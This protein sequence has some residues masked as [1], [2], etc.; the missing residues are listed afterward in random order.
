MPASRSA[1]TYT[2]R[3]APE[4]PGRG[5]TIIEKFED[6]GGDTPH[7]GRAIADGVGSIDTESVQRIAEDILEGGHEAFLQRQHRYGY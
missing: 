5:R 3:S 7:R 6:H 1:L 4:E 2:L